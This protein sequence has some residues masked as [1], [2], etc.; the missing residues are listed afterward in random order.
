[1]IYFR[2]LRNAIK[3]KYGCDSVRLRTEPV[4][5]VSGGFITWDGTVEVF[6]LLNFEK[7]KLCYVWGFPAEDEADGLTVISVLERPPVVSAETAV[8]AAIASG[9]ICAN[10]CVAAR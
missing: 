4:S 5:V 2:E 3:R 7:A 9:S 10:E 6:S 1:M 8:R